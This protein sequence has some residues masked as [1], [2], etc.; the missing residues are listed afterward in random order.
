[1]ENMD[2]ANLYKIQDE[3]FKI[4]FTLEN[5]FYLTGGTCLSRFYWEKRY[6]DDLCFFTNNSN[7][8]AINV[9]KILNNL[10]AKFVVKLE[11]ESKD[12]FR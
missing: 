7:L 1:M 3:I 9:R 2:Y 8:F 12:F 10:K 4:V 11:V 6:S 5:D